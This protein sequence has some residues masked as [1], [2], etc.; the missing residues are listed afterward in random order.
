M[1]QLVADFK[2]NYGTVDRYIDAYGGQLKPT[3]VEI[4]EFGLITLQMNRDIIYEADMVRQ[5]VPN[6]E[7]EIITVLPS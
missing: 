3:K 2:K 7:Q 1:S 6:Y 5:Y 4:D